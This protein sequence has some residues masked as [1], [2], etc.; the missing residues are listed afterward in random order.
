MREEEREN[1]NEREGESE[2]PK[3]K[4]ITHLHTATASDGRKNTPTHTNEK[5]EPQT[6]RYGAAQRCD[7]DT[8]GSC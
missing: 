1:E 8:F 7:F 2:R 4:Q 5:G 3:E 6:K